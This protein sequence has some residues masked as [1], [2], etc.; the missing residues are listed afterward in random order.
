[1]LWI[2]AFTALLAIPFGSFAAPIVKRAEVDDTLILQFLQ[3]MEQMEREFYWQI[4]TKF[5]DKD[6][7]NAGFLDANAPKRLLLEIFND[8]SIHT[9]FLTDGLR[10]QAVRGCTFT[11][12]D[13]LKD[14]KSAVLA[15]R[16]LEQVS[17]S[18]YL[19]AVTLVEDKNFLIALASI[20]TDEARHETTMNILSGSSVMPQSF[21]TA[22]RPEQVLSI[23]SPHMT[24]NLDIP[25]VKPLKIKNSL[26]KGEAITLE[27]DKTGI[28]RDQPL[29]CQILIGGQPAGLAQPLESCTMPVDAINGPLYIYITNDGTPLPANILQQNTASILAGPAIAW[30][31]PEGGE[32]NQFIVPKGI[33]V[34]TPTG[35]ANR[36]LT[37]NRGSSTQTPIEGTGETPSPQTEGESE[38][39]GESKDIT[40]KGVWTIPA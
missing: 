28:P 1:M 25:P 35:A 40:I 29:F 6:Y 3:A 34:E 13:A 12:D 9:S 38:P 4:Q 27:F 24:C 2:S 36:T 20:L 37:P 26:R 11:F 31:D 19:G 15:A 21:D 33:A 32:L 23:L 30:V 8:E 16:T 17:V 14:V 39:A 18:A 10:G 7:I 22:L 5:Q